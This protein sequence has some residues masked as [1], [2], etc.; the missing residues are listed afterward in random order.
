MQGAEEFREAVGAV[1][2]GEPSA[3]LQAPRGSSDE[4]FQGQRKLLAADRLFGVG[5]FKPALFVRGIAQNERKRLG[6]AGRDVLHGDVFH[7]K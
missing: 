5:V 7:G 3:E 2:E 6:I 1:H 4:L